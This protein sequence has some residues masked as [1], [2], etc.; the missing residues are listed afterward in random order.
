MCALSRSRDS[1]FLAS[2]P[3]AYQFTKDVMME[4]AAVAK[5]KGYGGVDEEM[6]EW[7][8]GRAR[9]RGLPGVQPSMMA[10]A[11]AG[12]RME[13]EAIVGNAVRLAGE[14]GVQVPLMRT[15]YMLAR[16]LD[17]SFRRGE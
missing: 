17:D 3:D 16:A 10:D 6:V 2:A 1:Q 4:I 12:R 14:R 11:I 5:A 13:V 9:A 7:Q 8:L 15:I